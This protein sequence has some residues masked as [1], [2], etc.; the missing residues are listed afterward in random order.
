MEF[1]GWLVTVLW[2]WLNSPQAPGCLL[3][4]CCP[5]GRR[6]DEKVVLPSHGVESCVGGGA[7]PR[8]LGKATP[9]ISL[10]DLAEHPGGRL[11][12]LSCDQ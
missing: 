5:P 10:Q 3:G 4:S 1:M 12:L 6:G 7:S 11:L 9:W 8:L 2:H